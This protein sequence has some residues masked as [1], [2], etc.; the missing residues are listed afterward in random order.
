MSE[1]REEMINTL[2]DVVIE[3]GV[4]ALETGT[5]VLLEVAQ[6]LQGIVKQ[7]EGD[8][9]HHLDPTILML[10]YAVG[11]AWTKS[12]TDDELEEVK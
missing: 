3:I 10:G 9:Y 6:L 5:P 11:V 2:D 4:N 12:T 1:T 8:V 7:Y